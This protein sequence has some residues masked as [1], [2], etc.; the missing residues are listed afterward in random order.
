MT[1]LF[2]INT[3]LLFISKYATSP[4]G[5]IAENTK[6]IHLWGIEGALQIQNH[7]LQNVFYILTDLSVV[8]V[9]KSGEINPARLIRIVAAA[10]AVAMCHVIGNRCGVDSYCDRTA[11]SQLVTNRYL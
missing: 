6:Q 1:S 9:V 4:L 5:D 3:F 7:K 10:H 2:L 8:F 11:I